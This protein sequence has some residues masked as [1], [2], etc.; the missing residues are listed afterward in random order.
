MPDGRGATA[1]AAEPEDAACERERVGGG[2]AATGHGGRRQRLAEVENTF[3]WNVLR[4]Q[5]SELKL[6]DRT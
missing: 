2:G 3:L 5:Q 6:L 4:C 1:T